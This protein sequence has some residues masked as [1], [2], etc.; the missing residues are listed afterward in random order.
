MACQE[1]RDKVEKVLTLLDKERTKK[2]YHKCPADNC[3]HIWGHR[4]TDFNSS[5]EHL[6]GHLCPK[7]KAEQVWKCT[8][9]G[10]PL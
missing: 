2:H 9:D 4:M 8:K 10:A 6:E 1:I 3:G 5:Q 7:C